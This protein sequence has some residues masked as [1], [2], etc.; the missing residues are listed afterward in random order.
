MDSDLSHSS[1]DSS[2]ENM[3]VFCAPHLPDDNDFDAA[4][5][6]SITWSDKGVF[7]TDTSLYPRRAAT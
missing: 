1:N 6:A 2:H 5:C 4:T 7:S 3:P